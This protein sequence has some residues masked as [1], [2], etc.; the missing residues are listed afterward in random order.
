MRLTVATASMSLVLVGIGCSKT[1]QAVL[2]TASTKTVKVEIVC[3]GDS[4]RA[5]V[6]PFNVTIAEYDSSADEIPWQLS[7]SSTVDALTITKKASDSKKW[8]YGAS[9]PIK[10]GKKES[11][12]SGK[13]KAGTEDG[14]Y[15]YN[16]SSSCKLASGDANI[17][18]D[19]DMI[20]I[21]RTPQ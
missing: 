15:G 10:I 19:P 1:D 5:L 13:L 21:H 2:K 7:D 18:I 8:P 3:E 20:I 14:R 17:V 9:L 12:K 16:I 11:G 4:V 6:S